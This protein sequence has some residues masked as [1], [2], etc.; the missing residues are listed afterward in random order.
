MPSWIELKLDSGGEGGEGG[1]G[2]VEGGVEGGVG[3]VEGGVGG[4]GLPW[5]FIII[6]MEATIT[7]KPITPPNNNLLSIY[8]TY[9]I[10]KIIFKIN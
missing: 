5:D 1:V 9:I 6:S 4:G 8:N 10:F 2:G 7:N 3:G